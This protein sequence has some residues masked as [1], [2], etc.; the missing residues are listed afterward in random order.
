MRVREQKKGV[1]FMPFLGFLNG[2]SDQ[3]SQNDH[4]GIPEMAA[5]FEKWMNRLKS[6]VMKYDAANERSL[7]D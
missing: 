5:F 7:M 4:L 1:C 3:A 6:D 2:H